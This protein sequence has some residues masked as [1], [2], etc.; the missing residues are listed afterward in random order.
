MSPPMNAPTEPAP[1]PEFWIDRGGTFTDCIGRDPVTGALS[2]TKVLSSN[3]APIEGIRAL[4]DLPPAAPIPACHVRMGTTIATNALLERRGAPCALVI[5]RGFRDALAIGTQA[6]PR[7]FDVRIDKPEL[8]YD[9]VVEVDARADA[10]G[11]IVARPDKEELRATL[12]AVKAGGID[13]L[14]VVVLHAYRA[15]QL[16]REI[17]EVARAVGFGHVSLSCEVANEL[18]LVGRGD[19]AVVDAYL[20][21]LIRDYVATLRKELPGSSLRLMQSSG[22]LIDA[23]G[24]RGRNSILSGPAAGVVACAHLARCHGLGGAIGFDMGGTS[25]DVS[26][27]DLDAEGEPAFERV[28]DTEVAGVRL[29]AP[30][31]AIHTVAAGGGSLCRYRGFRLTVGPESAG[32]S[33][34]PLCYGH[35][36]AS[37]PSVTDINLALGRVV[38]DRFPFPLR[39]NRVLAA[40]EDLAD[41]VAADGPRPEPLELAAGFFR[42]ATHN[43]AEAIRQISIARGIDP[44]DYALVVFGGA[45]GQHACAIARELG[46]RQLVLHRLSGVLSAYGMGLAD[47]TWTGERDA[48]R[49]PLNS[50][51][52]RDLAPVFEDLE[53][54][55]RAALSGEGFTGDRVASTRRVDLR[56]QGTQSPITVVF[57]TS[58]R[59]SA[60]F[61]EAH[62]RLFGYDRPDETIEVVTARV[63][64][65]GRDPSAAA[66]GRAGETPAEP[67]PPPTPQRMH[68]M[69]TP[70]GWVE[71]PLYDRDGIAP[72][73]RVAG[74]ALIVEATGTIAVDPGFRATAIDADTLV[75]AATDDGARAADHSHTTA[76]PIRLEIFNNLF[77]SIATQMG[78][79][80]QRTAVSTNIRERL[81]FS[82]AVF[83]A[84]GGL[85]A[86]APH[87]PVH[88]G[89]MAE[90]VRHVLAEHPHPR[91]GDVYATNDP[92][93]GGSHLP[94]I[95]VVTP[96][97]RDGKLVFFTASRGH[98]ADV[99]GITPG[100]MPPFSQNLAQEG[101]VLRALRIVSGGQFDTEGVLTALAASAYPARN[102]RGN[103]ADL[104]AQV[105]ANRTGALLLGEAMDRHGDDVVAAYMT[106]VQD[107][108]AA[109]VA[110]EIERLADGEHHFAD[111]L[112][113]GT[114]IAVTLRVAGSRMDIDF[115]G[116]GAQVGGNLNAPRAVTVA[117]VIYALRTLVDAPIPLNSGCL[118]PVSLH[119]PE[120]SVLSPAPDAAVCGGNVET[121]Q[122]VT[123]VLLA[124]LGCCAASQGTMNNLTF[125]NDD[126]GYYETIAGGAGAGRDFDGASGVHTHMTNTRITDAE[127]LESRFPV[128]LTEFSLRRGSG[129]EGHRAGGDGVIRELELLAPMR[130][131]ILSE[132]RERA[133]FG[134]AGGGAGQPGRNTRNG[135]DVGGKA[136]L[137]CD[138]GD[139]VRIETPGGGAWGK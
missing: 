114:P 110:A 106:H 134:L 66:S 10:N 46:M 121:S 1:R 28:Y 68:R 31:M 129:G 61:V 99:G 117:A 115:T 4:L 120:G 50:S 34:G 76:D 95:T 19:T 80:L 39:A 24:F 29:R 64:V 6:R 96:V 132:R 41:Q 126:F 8:L 78:T 123:D 79:A 113:D 67:A 118:R 62:R 27:V 82:C 90:S 83:D 65:I 127:V 14:A 133:P 20:T 45:G 58:Q 56:Y 89:A 103:L 139:R 16:E 72:G 25:T 85:V 130:V 35:E 81:D 55:G 100:S 101:V 107:N 22:G 44:R 70:D 125:G 32:A 122:R 91:P 54:A 124:A 52:D 3:R 128:R 86:N 2:V 119:I 30:M 43:M 47:V 63:E 97:F 13:S 59:A 53:A 11:D 36:G 15:E 116:T 7:I 102:P 12:A 108:A 69:W 92:A 21:P 131:S 57:E 18:G 111:A 94:D 98:H 88:L 75:V 109:R 84:D 71:A 74:P 138:R 40:L 42:I 33:P 49:V 105:A 60:A 137:E 135:I 77:M 5:T 26:R 73:A 23:D 112:D 87:I 51:V 9:R 17:G 93:G 37:E 136:S 104:Q 38:G 48:G